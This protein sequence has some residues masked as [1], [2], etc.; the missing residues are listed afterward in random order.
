MLILFYYSLFG[1]SKYLLD[2]TYIKWS[3]FET[4]KDIIGF[5]IEDEY[6]N[7][8]N[9]IL[10]S[11]SSNN[12]YNNLRYI[13]NK[14]YFNTIYLYNDI[15]NDIIN[16]FKYYDELIKIIN[17]NIKIILN[18]INIDNVY[19]N[20]K[21]NIYGHNINSIAF[22]YAKINSIKYL[23]TSIIFNLIEYFLCTYF[24]TE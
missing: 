2:I 10:Y 14:I 16:S 23:G 21:L 24:W 7:V 5:E 18:K 15:N 6:N 22:N 20:K 4:E 12:K 8:C 19:I 3:K 13:G 9:S 17:P 1:I 11:S